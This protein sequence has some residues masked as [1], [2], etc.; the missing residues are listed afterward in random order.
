MLFHLAAKA[1]SPLSADLTLT[2]SSI[3]LDHSQQESFYLKSKQMN[4]LE[5]ILEYFVH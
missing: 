5:Q 3:D 4:G 2:E 1:P